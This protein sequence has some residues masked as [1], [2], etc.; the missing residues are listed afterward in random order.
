MD[1]VEVSYEPGKVAL[2]AEHGPLRIIVS[3]TPSQAE[4]LAAALVA[5]ASAARNTI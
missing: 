3:F 1:K 4:Q 5:N 2:T